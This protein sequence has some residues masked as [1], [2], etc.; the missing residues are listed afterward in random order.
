MDTEFNYEKA[1]MRIK[2]IQTLIDKNEL[3]IDELAD[4]LKEAKSLV[5]ACKNKLKNIEEEV[6]QVIENTDA[7][8]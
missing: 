5:S 2:E 3:P 6:N 4:R 1:L 7:T 8:T